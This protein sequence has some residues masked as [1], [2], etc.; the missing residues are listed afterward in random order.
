MSACHLLGGRC[1]NSSFICGRTYAGKCQ[2]NLYSSPGK[3]SSA[4]VRWLRLSTEEKQYSSAPDC[5]ENVHQRKPWRGLIFA[6][7][8]G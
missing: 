7:L 3:A 6:D 1:Y 5:K 8:K 4:S 2:D